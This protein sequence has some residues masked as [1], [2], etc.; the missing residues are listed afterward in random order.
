L[1]PNAP[2]NNPGPTHGAEAVLAHAAD[3]GLNNPDT[4]PDDFWSPHAGGVNFLF[5]D[6]SVKNLK[7][8]IPLPIYRALCTRDFGEVISSVSYRAELAPV[9]TIGHRRGKR[10]PLRLPL[11]L[12]CF[13][14]EHTTGP[15]RRSR[16]WRGL[17]LR[18]HPIS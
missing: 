1:S 4:A 12:A 9:P 6:G 8:G 11:R 15:P 10:D 2:S 5:C 17:D 13:R 18:H 7:K 16:R 3:E 14:L